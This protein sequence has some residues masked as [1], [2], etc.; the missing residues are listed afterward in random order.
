[1]NVKQRY[2]KD[3]N[4][5]TFSPVTSTESIY[6]KGGKKLLD[7]FYPIGS[8]Y[9]TSDINFN[10]N[11]SWGGTWVQDTIGLVT[12]GA[13]TE[14][15]GGMGTENVLLLKVGEE[16]GEKTHTLTVQEI[17]S[18]YHMQ[19]GDYM[20][21]RGESGGWG[22][23]FTNTTDWCSTAFSPKD[24]ATGGSQSHNNIQPSIGV[25]RWHRT[26]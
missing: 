21:S 13:D 11:T 20:I 17:P 2:L 9:E 7:L 26:A 12:V 10:P 5:Q 3:E 8:Y 23:Q 22:L 4:G 6:G 24:T 19:S 16:Y 15:D 25:I 14:G 1:M 18:H